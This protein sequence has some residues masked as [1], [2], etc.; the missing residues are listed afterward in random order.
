MK[1]YK[2][3][4]LLAPIGVIAPIFVAASCSKNVETK[5]TLPLTKLVPPIKKDKDNPGNDIKQKDDKNKKTLMLKQISEA[6]NLNKKIKNTQRE[7][8]K[9]LD[10]KELAKKSRFLIEKDITVSA[11]VRIT[12]WFEQLSTMFP[13]DNDIQK[14]KQTVLKLKKEIIEKEVSWKTIED[15]ETLTGEFLTIYETVL[16]PLFYKYDYEILKKYL[17][18]NHSKFNDDIKGIDM[19]LKENSEF[20]EAIDQ[21]LRLVLSGIDFVKFPFPKTR[22]IEEQTE[23]SFFNRFFEVFYETL[24]SEI[25]ENSDL[26]KQI[27]EVYNSISSDRSLDNIKIAL[28]KLTKIQSQARKK[29]QQ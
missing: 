2:H 28:N 24:K 14:N 21:I 18:K 5:K 23:A 22:Y 9:K 19:K 20:G 10:L 4:L 25:E 1:K 26:I 8:L 13:N 16:K 29:T 7:N 12:D 27:D 15:T 3:L 11:I 17:E 6:K